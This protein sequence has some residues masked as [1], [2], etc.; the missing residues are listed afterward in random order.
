[1]WGRVERIIGVGQ[2]LKDMPILR[3]LLGIMIS[4]RTHKGMGPSSWVE[5]LDHDSLF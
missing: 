4:L 5:G 3:Y 2:E 1:M